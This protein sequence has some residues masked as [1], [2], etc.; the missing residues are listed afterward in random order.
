IDTVMSAAASFTL[1]ANL[2]NL[3]LIGSAL[4][5]TGNALSNQLTGDAE[6]NT[7]SGGA[8]ADVMRGGAGNDLYI[9]DNKGD[10]AIEDLG[11]GT[12]EIRSSVPLLTSFDNVE[13]YTFTGT[14][15]VK[16][17]GNDLD[18]KISG[19]AYAD[20]LDGGSGNNTLSGGA[21][22]DS[23]IGGAGNDVY[24]IDNAGDKINDSGGIDT[25]QSSVTL[26]LVNS[27]TV[28][29]QIEHLTLTGAGA[30]NGTGNADNNI[31][32]GNNAVNK[33][34]GNGGDD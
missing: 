15:A 5:G 2:E 26:S 17:T 11:A 24:V 23:L 1:G 21:G 16:F 32:T 30:I 33:L 8:G 13:N 25:V 14:A 7:L 3:V 31:I 28:Q 6:N 12:D 4:T 20:T 9:F 27:A 19:T 22:A 29:G 34:L 10:V 18:N